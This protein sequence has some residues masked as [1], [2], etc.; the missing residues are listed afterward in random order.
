VF[1]PRPAAWVVVGAVCGLL[2][3]RIVLADASPR[4]CGEAVDGL[5]YL[6]YSHPLPW[7]VWPAGAFVGAVI[8]AVVRW[9]LRRFLPPR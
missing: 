5:C 8:A 9:S 1:N 4:T 6:V 3:V 2:A 7:F